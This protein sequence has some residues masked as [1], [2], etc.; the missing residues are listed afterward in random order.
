MIFEILPEDHNRDFICTARMS[1][2][3]F[4]SPQYFVLYCRSCK[5]CK[6][7][8]VLF[9]IIIIAKKINKKKSFK[10][11]TKS[12]QHSKGSTSRNVVRV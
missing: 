11:M 5:K 4:C 12:G 1:P 8:L 10:R 2:S 6:N 7:V 9:K 3:Y